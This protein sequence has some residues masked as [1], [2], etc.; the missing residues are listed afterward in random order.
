MIA[1]FRTIADL[2]AEKCILAI[3]DGNHGGSH[4]KASEYVSKGIPFIM[5][6]D[7][8]DGRL[9]LKEA[10]RLP[11]LRTD[12]LRIGFSLPGDVLITHKGTVGEVA[13]VPPVQDYIML[14][15]Q[16]TYY[17]TDNKKLDAQ[18][19]SFAFRS[20]HFQSQLLNISAQSTR[21]YVAIS[22]Q[23][24]L[25]VLWRDIG[26]QRR[27]ASILGAYDDLIEVN[28]RR[29]AVLEE[30]ARRLFDEWFVHFRFPGH[31]GHAIVETEHGRLPTGWRW[32]DLGSICDRIT[33]G[34]HYS[35]A[36]VET[37]RPMASVKDMRDW[38][39]DLTRCRVIAEEDYL[40]LVHGDCQPTIGDVVIAK[41]G[42]NLNKHTFL[43][44][45]HLPIVLLSSIAILRPNS[46]IEREFLVAKLRSEKT[47]EAIKLMKSG[48]A[49]PRIV[50][51]DFKRLQILLPPEKIRQRFEHRA[52]ALHHGCRTLVKTNDNL[53]KQRDLL[54]PRLISGD[55]SVASAEREL[56][57]AE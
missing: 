18:Y 7:I 11:K 47:S 13:I 39:F 17:R 43:I 46:N 12:K 28:R 42:A 24:H 48:A 34:S 35:P 38:D 1:Q 23:R 51:R 53:A 22:T 56:E 16:V 2:E 5:A 9:N 14:T 54:L 27:I 30:M 50:L 41:D 10:T 3:Q 31:E 19:L 29:I 37:G 4:P 8:H 33:D 45:A 40:A 52:G 15:P 25:I 20:P 26:T 44:C 57:A 55:L 36:S 49:I 21:P 32:T 6:S